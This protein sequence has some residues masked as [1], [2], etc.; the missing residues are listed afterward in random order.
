[1]TTE[2]P[3]KKSSAALTTRT[4]L[5]EAMIL[6]IAA[7][8]VVADEEIFELSRTVSEHPIFEGNDV[9]LIAGEFKRAL[10][11]LA[12][13]GF[14]ARLGSLASVLDDY[15]SRLLAFSF[16]T[17]ICFSD[18]DL[19]SQ[20]LEL[21]KGFQRHFGLREE[22]VAL[23]VAAVQEQ[24]PVRSVLREIGIDD[25]PVLL[26]RS[27]AMIELMMLMAAADGEIQN[28]EVTRMALTV[29]SRPEFKEMSEE[30]ISE[31]F[32]NALRRVQTH[33]PVDRLAELRMSLTTSEERL[34]AL[35]FAFSI[36]VADGIATVG[37]AQY[38][39]DIRVAFD[40]DEDSIERL[41]KENEG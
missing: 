39:E 2:A 41:T 21:L 20:E 12:E 34:Q 37:E 15:P 19:A 23:I 32:D 40:L 4:S 16:A 17:G 22:H 24:E 27:E 36:L 3:F 14:E 13:E 31:A 9:E 26:S 8:G 11:A 1:M 6:M 29:A 33:G 28:V 25:E 10:R 5:I 38:L 18:G 7:D 30:D 35:R